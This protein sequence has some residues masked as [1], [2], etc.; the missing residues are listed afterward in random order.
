MQKTNRPI[1]VVA[2]LPMGLRL[3]DHPFYYNAY[4]ADP[5]KIGERTP[6][7]GAKVWTASR[8]PL[9]SRGW[10]ECGSNGFS[11]THRHVRLRPDTRHLFILAL[12]DAQRYVP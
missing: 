4:A 5:K 9:D 8:V 12:R 3:Q 6:V 11:R 7:I 10:R 2:D 1:P